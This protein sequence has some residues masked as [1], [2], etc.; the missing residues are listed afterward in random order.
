MRKILFAIL[1][2]LVADAYA[3][4]PA[5]GQS[6]WQ[7]L[8][9][10]VINI[11]D[12]DEVELQEV[13]EHLYDLDASPLNINDATYEDMVEI[14]GMTIDMISD[15]MLYRDKY[16]A[17]RTMEELALIPS[18]DR[19]MRLFLACI[20]VAKPSESDPYNR[21]SVRSREWWRGERLDSLLR[22][23]RGTVLATT[24]IPLYERKGDEGK[25]LGDKYKYS[26]KLKGNF[27]EYI[28]YG[29]VA[30]K[31]AGEPIFTRGNS[32][33]FD[34][35]S[36]YVNINKVYRL[37]TLMLGCYRM[38][39]AHGLVLNNG[40]SLGKQSLTTSAGV[41]QT[42]IS[43]H[44]SR[45]DGNYL[46]GAAATIDLSR[47][48]YYERTPYT[49]AAK[50]ELTGFFSYR[51]HDATLNK[52]GTM[53]TI[54]TTGYHRTDTEMEKKNNTG[55]MAA[56]G[57]LTWRKGAWQFGASGVYSWYN[58]DFRQNPTTEY[59]RYYPN[60]NA[61]WN[62]SIDYSYLSP[63]FSVT[64]ETATGSCG[65]IAT[66]NTIAVTLPHQVELTAVQRFYSYKYYA[67]MARS[68]SDGGR[69]QNESGAYLALRMPVW[70][71]ITL[72]VYTD[73]AYFPWTKYLA[74]Q[75]SYSWDNSLSLTH[76]HK[77]WTTQARY[78]YHLRQRTNTEKTGNAN[79]HEHT[80]RLS[81]LYMADVVSLRTQVDYKFVS[82]QQKRSQGYMLSEM[83]TWSMPHGR[84]SRLSPLT[85]SLSGAYFHTNDYDSRA[86]VY[87]KGMLESFSFASVYGEGFRVS[88]VVRTDLSQHW[89][90]MAKA[91]HTKY[92]DRSEISSAD[93]L[94]PQSYQ[95]D[96]DVQIRYKF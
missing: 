34:Y 82:T 73:L 50:I 30:T 7:E 16:G 17:M 21:N 37:K 75:G 91:G 79:R 10:E 1:L 60:G 70:R 87:E 22:H 66:V 15:I 88:A 32:Q 36:Y 49:T 71:R 55:A 63:R 84:N 95:T 24:Q 3:Q 14:P 12:Y 23:G 86:Y 52:D 6:A 67:M 40:F 62:A 47:T 41:P 92:F 18:I 65:A 64:G 11:D 33:G 83:L 89:M 80:G 25:Y 29:L 20:F 8:L 81:A 27:S 2:S 59:R 56:G 42:T 45:S 43:G 5:G 61:F 93:R 69:V 77:K 26:I 68:F 28:K 51:K 31:D 38:K 53:T 96:I 57:H 19:T 35:Y 94:I 9:P 76:S 74:K 39:M 85:V 72:D 78:R 46:Q 90:L 4:T 54:V 58:R 44:V 48:P 13:Y